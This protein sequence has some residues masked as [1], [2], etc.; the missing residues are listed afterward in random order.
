MLAWLKARWQ[1]LVVGAVVLLAFV[2]GKGLT[3]DE[4]RKALALRKLTDV[5]QR[6]LDT[7]AKADQLKRQSDALADALTRE[8]EQVEAQ[9]DAARRSSHDAVVLDLKR[10]RI[11]K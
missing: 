9:K 3:R 6:H 10:R 11:I 8:K 7:Q 5:T 4:V 2:L 1:W